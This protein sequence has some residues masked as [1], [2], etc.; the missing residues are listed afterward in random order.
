MKYFLI[1]WIIS[2]SVSVDCPDSRVFDPVTQEYKRTF[3]ANYCSEMVSDTLSLRFD[4]EAELEKHV[5]ALKRDH[6]VQSFTV[7]EVQATVSQEWKREIPESVIQDNGGWIDL[8][9][10]SRIDTSVITVRQD[11]EI[12]LTAPPIIKHLPEKD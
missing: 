10:E 1:T 7:E 12:I 8:P 2:F 9:D 6:R 4:S 5:E 3:L 11:G